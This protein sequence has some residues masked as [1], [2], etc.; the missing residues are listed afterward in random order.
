[1]P[2]PLRNYYPVGRAAEL[3]ECTIDDLICWGETGRIRLCIRLNK[4]TGLLKIY[5]LLMF[6]DGLITDLGLPLLDENSSEEDRL[7]QAIDNIYSVCVNNL[8]ILKKI[9]DKT[10]YAILYQ[11]FFTVNP[12]S[13][14]H[15]R[16]DYYSNEFKYDFV[17]CFLGGE[18]CIHQMV[19][20]RGF[21]ALPG[22][23]FK[24]C[25]EFESLSG[26]GFLYTTD[27]LMEIS[28]CIE[29]E[30]KI[31]IDDLFI[32]KKDFIRIKEASKK[33]DELT[34]VF[35]ELHS[36]HTLLKSDGFKFNRVSS[37]SVLALKALIINHYPDIKD[38]PSKLANVLTAEAKKAGLDS[39]KFNKDTVSR[40]M[41]ED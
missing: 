21:F 18:Q 28:P 10:C 25:G 27:Y 8:K 31:T 3:L 24:G 19:S 32:L 15:L 38:N 39:I 7:N 20:M 29:D 30:I 41:K 37:I 13:D 9:R 1:M 5:N 11:M 14:C 4:I 6:Y 2:L 23:F 17:K 26:D 22:Y 12:D 16:S 34:E 35:E 33:G 40:W 36:N